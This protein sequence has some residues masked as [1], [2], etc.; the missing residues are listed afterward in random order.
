MCVYIYIWS[1]ECE[2][3]AVIFDAR[4]VSCLLIVSMSICTK[5]CSPH[6][7]FDFPYATFPN[8]PTYLLKFHYF[9]ISHVH[10]SQHPNLSCHVQ[11][12]T[13]FPQSRFPTSQ[14]IF[15]RTIPSQFPIC[16]FPNIPIY[17]STYVPWCLVCVGSDVWSVLVVMFSLCW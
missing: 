16:T 9:P 13:N 7:Q 2:V 11:Y 5:L 14:H 10:V 8:I 12:L 4:W 6:F 17:L 1:V 15:P 3:G